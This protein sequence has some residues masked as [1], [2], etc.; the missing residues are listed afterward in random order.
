MIK[1]RQMKV[2]AVIFLALSATSCNSGTAN[3]KM[4]AATD[5]TAVRKVTGTILK[6]ILSST[7]DPKHDSIAKNFTYPATFTLKDTVL[8]DQ[9]AAFGAAYKVWLGP[10][11]WTARGAI[12]G[13]GDILVTLLPPNC[14]LLNGPYI[15]Y[16]DISSCKSCILHSA[17]QYFPEALTK[18]NAEYNKDN[19]KPVELP[20][21]LQVKRISTDI[22][23][24][25]KS[26]KK[27]VAIRGVVSYTES[28]HY[29]EAEFALPQQQSG[30]VDLLMN[31]FIEQVRQ[32]RAH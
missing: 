32:K 28:G 22:I 27:G 30:L 7:L 26:W 17:A 2:L 24:Y 14:H 3:N 29:Y 21:G 10:K 15:V 18:Y 13:E 23:T 16:S 12:G 4:A 8:K 20:G 6:V 31:T 1:L 5:T 11:G 9:L 19:A 25:A